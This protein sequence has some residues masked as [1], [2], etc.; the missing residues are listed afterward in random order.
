MDLLGSNP[1]G[2]KVLSYCPSSNGEHLLLTCLFSGHMKGRGDFLLPFLGRNMKYVKP[3][4]GTFREKLYFLIPIIVCYKLS[5]HIDEGLSFK[6]GSQWRVDDAE[7]W[8]K[9][10]QG[11]LGR[12]AVGTLPHGGERNSMLR[13]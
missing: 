6:M 9:Q 12:F 13:S 4:Q 8:T 2:R 1:A 10:D 11:V 7:G 3:F 5:L